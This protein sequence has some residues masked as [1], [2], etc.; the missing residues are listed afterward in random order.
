MTLDS[1][2][3]S[4]FDSRHTPPSSIQPGAV[5]NGNVRTIRI[6][7]VGQ[8]ASPRGSYPRPYGYCGFKSHLNHAR[9]CL[10]VY[11]RQDRKSTLSCVSPSITTRSDRA[12]V[13]GQLVHREQREEMDEG[14]IQGSSDWL[15]EE[16]L[17]LSDKVACDSNDCKRNAVYYFSVK[18]CG[19]VS[20][21]CE[22]CTADIFAW[23]FEL[24]SRRALC[25]CK[26]CE[27]RVLPQG[28]L[29]APKKIS[30]A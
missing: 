24:I 26:F 7:S 17:N 20:F 1:F 19:G 2:E 18:C 3:L 28:W 13:Q 29:S 23:I 10:D 11:V 14:K 15:A 22:T 12:V 21:G 16:G 6:D 27:K 4:G 9:G 8:S 25:T 30:K 5:L